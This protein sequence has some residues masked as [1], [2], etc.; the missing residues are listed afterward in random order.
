MFQFMSPYLG[1]AMTAMSDSI[2]DRRIVRVW[3]VN[4]SAGSRL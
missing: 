2:D 4:N 3:V 1:P